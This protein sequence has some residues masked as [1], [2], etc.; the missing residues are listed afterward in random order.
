M[1]LPLGVVVDNLKGSRCLCI[2]AGSV[3]GG[4][5]RKAISLKIPEIWQKYWFWQSGLEQTVA[6]C[7]P[8]IWY[9]WILA[10]ILGT[11]KH[12]KYTWKL[13]DPW[14]CLWLKSL[15]L[16]NSA[17]PCWFMCGVTPWG[18]Y[19]MVGKPIIDIQLLHHSPH[20]LTHFCGHLCN[21]HSGLTFQTEKIAVMQLFPKNFPEIQKKKKNASHVFS[22]SLKK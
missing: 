14:K 13:V 3:P 4:W 1:G 7:S 18:F 20:S 19:S 15:P 22:H 5:L 8:Y 17:T 16:K 2:L 9:I 10:K 21:V 11:W 12:P 6:L